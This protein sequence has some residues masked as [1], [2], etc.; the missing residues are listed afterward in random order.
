MSAA[1]LFEDGFPHGTATGYEQGCRGAGC[2]AELEHGL[3]CR[4]AYTKSHGDYQ[5]QKLVRQGLTPAAIAAALAVA[6]VEHHAPVIRPAIPREEDQLEPPT[7][8][9][10]TMNKPAPTPADIKPKPQPAP[11]KVQAHADTIR[12]WCHDNG[13]EVGSRG[14]LP[15]RIKEA[16]LAGDP[17]LAGSKPAAANKTPEPQIET[18]EPEIETPEATNATPKPEIETTAAEVQS[19]LELP[20]AEE[21]VP[22]GI[23][24]FANWERELLAPADPLYIDGEKRLLGDALEFLIRQHADARDEANSAHRAVEG[25]AMRLADA[26]D[27][28]ASLHRQ[29]ATQAAALESAGARYLRL[30]ADL[31]APKPQ[32]RWW[33]R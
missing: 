27:V 13:I 24:P 19:A 11:P 30:L 16:F 12:A 3:S 31:E 28:N 17:S 29:I 7:R 5:Y 23:E 10:P 25:L 15:T 18:P 21:S 4:V 14:T 32:T 1:D 6:P 8:K 33:K 20:E 26:M 2:P 9:E 22:Y